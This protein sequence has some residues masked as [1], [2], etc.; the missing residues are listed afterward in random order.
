[1]VFNMNHREIQTG[2]PC[3]LLH[4]YEMVKSDKSNDELIGML[5]K[6]VMRF[7]I[8]WTERQQSEDKKALS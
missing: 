7:D 8:I 3:E 4:F 5:L 2:S 6:I 1:M